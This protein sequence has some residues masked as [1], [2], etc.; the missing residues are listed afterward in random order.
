MSEP[1]NGGRERNYQLLRQ[2]EELHRLTLGSISDAVFLTDDEGVFTFICPNVDVIFGYVPDE[3]QAMRTIGKLLGEGLFD[4]AQLDA[5]GEIRNLERGVVSK[6]GDGRTLLVNVK[7]VSINR[8]AVLYTCRDVT[9][10]KRAEEALRQARQ[11][12]AH[13]SRLAIAGELLASIGHEIRQPLTSILANASAGRRLG[14]AHADPAEF[15]EIFGDIEAQAHVASQTIDR[16][17]A[18]LR[19]QPFEARALDVGEAV[20]EILRFVESDAR[21]RGVT[22]QTDIADLLPAVPAD[23]ILLHQV[24]M[25]LIVNAM[26]SMDDVA[27]NER[28]LTVRTRPVADAI[29]VAVSDAGHGIPSERLP[30]VFDRFFTTKPDGIGLGLAISRTIV[31]AHH[32]QIWAEN[33]VGRGATFRFTLPTRVAAS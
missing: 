11:E 25:N 8:G 18:L 1:T 30:R 3:V 10:R 28:R 5:E 14:E 16:L 6:S 32:G 20:R 33:H 21:R 2:S 27:V 26:E 19:K 23:R 24:L 7:R 9:E 4:R 29:E 13:A 12:L 17:R 22:V 31:E 15:A